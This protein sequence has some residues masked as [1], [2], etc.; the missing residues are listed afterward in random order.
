MLHSVCNLEHGGYFAV[1]KTCS[2]ICCG[3][4]ANFLVKIFGGNKEKQY[5]RAIKEL[6]LLLHYYDINARI[7][8]DAEISGKPEQFRTS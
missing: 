5:I 8:I 2:S 3:C 4:V 7:N 1:V 6:A